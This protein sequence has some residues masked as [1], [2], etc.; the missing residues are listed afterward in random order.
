VREFVSDGR[1][2]EYVSIR[3]G[4]LFH[5]PHTSLGIVRDGRVV[6]GVVFNFHTAH[7][8]HVTVAASHPRAFTKVFLTRLGDYVWNELSCARISINTEQPRVIEIA[9]RLGAV[10]EG[11][12]RDYYGPG[13][14]AT[15]LGLLNRDWPFPK[16]LKPS[17]QY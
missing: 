17:S 13:R 3:T 4:V 8:I 11:T 2:V 9:Q 7:D 15:I 10:I 6:A 1:I 16:R 14:D 5:G 12:K